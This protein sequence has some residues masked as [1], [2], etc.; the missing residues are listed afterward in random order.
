MTPTRQPEPIVV[1]RHIG[2][3]AGLVLAAAAAMV[4]V[5]MVPDDALARRGRGFSRSFGRRSFG[6][7]RGRSLFSK[8]RSGGKRSLFGR[9]P[10]KR[11]SLFGR[12]SRTRGKGG[13]FGRKRSRR[14]RAFHRGK[15]GSIGR[16]TTSLSQRRAQRRA[17][18]AMSSRT[19]QSRATRYQRRYRA[20]RYRFRS[21]Y[22]GRPWGTWGWGYRSVGIWDLFFLSTVNHMFW[23][24]HWH[25]PGIKRALYQ[26][27]VLQKE[28]LKRL[29]KRVAELEKQGVQRDST[30]LPDDVDPDLAYSR[31]YVHHHKEQFES[32]A[33]PATAAASESG[34][35]TEPE[36]E[37]SSWLWV[38]FALFGGA[39]FFYAFFV[40]RY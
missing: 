34:S 6:G 36:E 33:T 26:D 38:L 10:G 1:R 14:G 31:E 18:R 9:S 2:N 16:K 3:I 21:S 24:H 4:F 5:T 37:S 32:A 39:V 30:Y 12:Q 13:L 28:E 20:P 15:S 27:N 17:R 8:R 40:R 19:R 22:Y 35:H 23:Y 11:R 29:E 25:D 7:R